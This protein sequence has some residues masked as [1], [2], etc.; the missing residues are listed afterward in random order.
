M[1]HADACQGLDTY[2]I[3]SCLE[4]LGRFA[5]GMNIPQAWPAAF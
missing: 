4:R 2:P 5:P 3:K 1:C